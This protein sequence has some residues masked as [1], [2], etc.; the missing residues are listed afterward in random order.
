MSAISIKG[1]VIGTVFDIVASGIFGVVFV[2]IYAATAGITAPEDLA[3][4]ATAPEFRVFSYVSGG[5]ISIIAG[6]LAARIAG[7]GELVNGTLSSVLCVGLGLVAALVSHPPEFGIKEILQFAF[8]PL[9]GLL[10]GYLR[11][12]QVQ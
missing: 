8:S 5:L 4:V 11:L 12:R 10:G 6:Y 2:M 9:L 1:V 7:R 3:G